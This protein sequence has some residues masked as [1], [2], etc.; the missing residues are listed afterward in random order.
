MTIDF[1]AVIKGIW[2]SRIGIMIF[3]LADFNSS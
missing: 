3:R 1:G 2:F